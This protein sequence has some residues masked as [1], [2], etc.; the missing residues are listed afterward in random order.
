VEAAV[1]WYSW[2]LSVL[3]A[4]LPPLMTTSSG[5]SLCA[6]SSQSVNPSGGSVV[7]QFGRKRLDLYGRPFHACCFEQRH[8]SGAST[9]PP[10]FLPEL[11]P[12][13]NAAG[14]TSSPPG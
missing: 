13:V 6:D 1:C 5:W 10:A 8:G 2:W 12:P 11:C 4:A 9:L 3:A 14:L 7:S